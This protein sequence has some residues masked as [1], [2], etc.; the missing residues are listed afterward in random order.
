MQL[1]MNLREQIDQVFQNL[2]LVTSTDA[3]SYSAS[4][5]K[6]IE[7]QFK[8]YL[9]S[10]EKFKAS[11]AKVEPEID[12][13]GISAATAS[14]QDLI[15]MVGAAAKRQDLTKKENRET[16]LAQLRMAITPLSSSVLSLREEIAK[17]EK[18]RA[19]YTEKWGK[20]I[21]AK[22]DHQSQLV[23]QLSVGF[24]VLTLLMA[25]LSIQS[26]QRGFEKLKST[27]VASG[28]EISTAS[29]HL[30]E[31][32][33]DLGE[34]TEIST[35]SIQSS[36]QSIDSIGKSVQENV[37]VAMGSA[38]KTKESLRKAVETT[39]L[40]GKLNLS[41]KEN[42]VAFVKVEEM[43]QIIDDITFQTNLLA[44]NAAVEAARAGEHGKGF[45]VVAD[46][47]RELALK[48]AQASGHI[49]TVISESRSRLQSGSKLA[50][51][52]IAAVKEINF[53]IEE[54]AKA[55]E[56]VV[57]SSEDQ[58]HQVRSLADLLEELDQSTKLNADVSKDVAA[59]SEQLNAQSKSLKVFVKEFSA[60][61][62]GGKGA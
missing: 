48:T 34:R 39:L 35:A 10:L 6:K 56:E 61:I 30:S 5:V 13:K 22:S 8:E 26:I 2:L 32:S 17:I 15:D 47:V 40:I 57:Q 38:T 1:G 52:G 16:F 51:D 24:T 21:E 55:N 33:H 36:V 23:M 54:L 9:S 14:V 53:S 50:D 7:T 46:A 62:E 18:H 37:K 58:S 45:A 31:T 27:L 28:E 20:S 12:L 19:E 49:S 42:T 44:L 60:F 4:D 29:G 43:L 3:D 25:F 41:L 11:L 59:S